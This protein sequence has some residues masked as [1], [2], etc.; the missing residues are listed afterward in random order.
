MEVATVVEV[1]MLYGELPKWSL[2]SYGWGGT[3]YGVA[4]VGGSGQSARILGRRDYGYG[5]GYCTGS[6]CSP[7]EH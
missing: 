4:D 2:L 1:E 3:R 6:G 5:E 7:N